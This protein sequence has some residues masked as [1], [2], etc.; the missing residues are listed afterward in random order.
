[1]GLSVCQLVSAALSSG[2]LLWNELAVLERKEDRDL[3]TGEKLL[4]IRSILAER[5]ESMGH[6]V[7]EHRPMQLPANFR[8]KESIFPQAPAKRNTRIPWSPATKRLSLFC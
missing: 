3:V 2:S 4:T 7:L 8:W 6:A 1:M 5:L